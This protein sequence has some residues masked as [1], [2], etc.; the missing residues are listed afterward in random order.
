M[1]NDTI[2]TSNTSNTGP[3]TITFR[4]TKKHFDGNGHFI[5]ITT[6]ERPQSTVWELNRRYYR[7]HEMCRGLFK[8][9]LKQGQLCGSLTWARNGLCPKHQS[10][11]SH[12][13]NN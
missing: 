4:N 10:Q 8:S 3:N 6:Y 5:D 12:F 11:E 7:V 1:S 13:G 9:G 2:N